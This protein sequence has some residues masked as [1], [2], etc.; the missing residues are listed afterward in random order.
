M[1]LSLA[2]LGEASVQANAQVQ[3]LSKFSFLPRLIPAPQALIRFNRPERLE[4]IRSGRVVSSHSGNS[5]QW[6]NRVAS[7]L[8]STGDNLQAYSVMVVRVEEVYPPTQDSDGSV[9]RAKAYGPLTFLALLGTAMTIGLIIVSCV[10]DDGMSLLATLCISLLSCL[11]GIGSKWRLELP[12]R[13]AARHVP[14][15]D[16]IIVYPQGAFV[17]VKCSEDTQRQL[18]WHPEECD[19]LVGE[20]TYRLIALT[21]TLLLMA[22]VIFLGNAS[23]P[24][25]LAWVA[26]YVM[27]HAAYWIVAALPSRLHW[28]FS[29]F[30]AHRIHFDG[31]GPVDKHPSFTQALWR[32]IAITR[33]SSWARDFDIAPKSRGW[34]LWLEEAATVAERWGERFDDEK[35]MQL[36]YWDASDRLSSIL[37]GRHDQEERKRQ[38]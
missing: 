28:D 15:S 16:V 34:D 10:Y 21:C 27:L 9:V 22:G 36:P 38:V 6:L 29:A 23:T 33:S 20:Q 3:A 1:A 37:E 35:T 11:I 17:I 12:Q 30:H 26:A 31:G 8:H 13:R 4:P 24:L 2:I 32:A 18:Y 19:Y 5:R 7:I 25:Q 14:R